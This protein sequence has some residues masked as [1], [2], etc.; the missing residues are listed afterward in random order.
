LRDQK[1]KLPIGVGFGYRRG[2]VCGNMHALNIQDESK[3]QERDQG[4]SSS[5]ALP[6]KVAGGAA[7]G[8]PAHA[9]LKARVENVEEAVRKSLHDKDAKVRVRNWLPG[10]PLV[11]PDGEV[12]GCML[13][14]HATRTAHSRLEARSRMRH[15]VVPFGHTDALDTTRAGCFDLPKHHRLDG[16]VHRD[17]HDAFS[18]DD[19]EEDTD[20]EDDIN[21]DSTDS[22]HTAGAGAGVDLEAGTGGAVVHASR[23]GTNGKR[24]SVQET[25]REQGSLVDLALSTLFGQEVAQVTVGT[26]G[27]G[28]TATIPVRKRSDA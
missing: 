14:A 17:E 15:S 19:E 20:D 23:H 26:G 25:S 6:K 5:Q 4:A 27:R 13:E 2:S 24:R 8:L 28:E 11:A 22:E 10:A 7:G 9:A 16:Y 18:D 1:L 3:Q 21:S 12:T